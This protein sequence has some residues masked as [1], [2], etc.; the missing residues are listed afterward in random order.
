[1]DLHRLQTCSVYHMVVVALVTF[2]AAASDTPQS[3]TCLSRETLDAVNESQ[4]ALLQRNAKLDIHQRHGT[5]EECVPACMP[6]CPGSARP[7]KPCLPPSNVVGWPYMTRTEWRAE[8]GERILKAVTADVREEDCGGFHL[9]GDHV[10]CLDAMKETNAM[11]LSYGIEQRD[12][13]SEKMSNLFHVPSRLYDCFADLDESPPMAKTAPNGVGAGACNDDVPC[14]EM[15]YES[16]RVCLGAAPEL[17]E[18]RAYETLESHLLDRNPL[19]TYVKMDVEGSE[20]D[21]L[22]HLLANEELQNKIRT[23]DMEVHFGYAPGFEIDAAQEPVTRQVEI[24]ERLARAF[25][26]TGSTLEVYREGWRPG[27]PG[28]TEKPNCVEPNV[29]MEN[30][31]SMAQ[32]AVSFVNRKLLP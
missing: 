2:L 14:Y 29:H 16:K 28:C 6:N 10:F 19:S 27:K 7:G 31:F 18:G 11:A 24:F 1:M 20:W 17:I 15:P 22:D 25:H 13:W 32:F 12:R 5:Q 26:V 30:G 4:Q 8:L 3:S 23:L 9:Y 21:V